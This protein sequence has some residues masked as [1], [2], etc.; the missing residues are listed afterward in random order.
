MKKLCT[1]CLMFIVAVGTYAQVGIG[2]TAPNA[3]LEIKASS[4]KNPSNTEC[5]LFPK[6]DD[7]PAIDPNMDQQGMLILATGIEEP[8]KG[9]YFWNTI[10]GSW[11]LKES[12][13]E[14]TN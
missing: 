12:P 9:F 6:V 14:S 8:G 1:L 2:T 4:Q 5:I 13:L 10:S 3:A 7:F 11:N